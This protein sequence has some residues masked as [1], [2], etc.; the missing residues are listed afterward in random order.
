M[1]CFTIIYRNP[2]YEDIIPFL[3]DYFCFNVYSLT[4]VL[5][6][7][8]FTACDDKPQVN[9][10]LIEVFEVYIPKEER[11]VTRNPCE[12]FIEV[13]TGHDEKNRIMLDSPLWKTKNLHQ[14]KPLGLHCLLI[15][16][17]MHKALSENIIENK[18]IIDDLPSE[19]LILSP[20]KLSPID[21]PSK[22]F[23]RSSSKS[24]SA[25]LSSLTEAELAQNKNIRT[26]LEAEEEA[27]IERETSGRRG[28]VSVDKDNNKFSLEAINYMKGCLTSSL[29]YA[30][31]EFSTE[32]GFTYDALSDF[33]LYR[34]FFYIGKGID[35][36]MERLCYYY[37]TSLQSCYFI[38]EKVVLP[39]TPTYNQSRSLKEGSKIFNLH[40]IG[41]YELL[42]KRIKYVFN[43]FNLKI[44]SH[45]SRIRTLL[46]KW[47]ELG[48]TVSTICY[49]PLSE[50]SKLLDDKNT[51]FFKEI[52]V[53]STVRV[54]EKCRNNGFQDLARSHSFSALKFEST[55]NSEV[56]IELE[57]KMDYVCLGLV[58]SGITPKY[59]IL[60]T[61]DG[62]NNFCIRLCYFT[63][64]KFST[65]FCTVKRMGFP[66]DWNCYI[67]LRAPISQETKYDKLSNWY[68]NARLPV[69]IEETRRHVECT[70]SVPLKVHL[71]LQSKNEESIEMMKILKDYGQTLA[72]LGSSYQI[73][74]YKFFYNADV[75]IAMTRSLKE[76]KLCLHN[77]PPII[78]LNVN[79]ILN[80]SNCHLFLPQDTKMT[81]LEP[82]ILKAKQLF[83]SFK[84]AIK[85]YIIHSAS[86]FGL[87]TIMN[88]TNF[89][90][91]DKNYY[92]IYIPYLSLP[93]I[94]SSIF[95]NP[96]ISLDKPRASEKRKHDELTTKYFPKY[97]AYE[98]FTRDFVLTLVVV[99][100]NVSA[101]SFV[102]L[103]ILHISVS[104]Y[105]PNINYEKLFWGSIDT[106]TV[107]QGLINT[108]LNNSLI[109]FILYFSVVMV[110][111]SISAQ[112]DFITIRQYFPPFHNR[113]WFKYSFLTILIHLYIVNRIYNSDNSVQLNLFPL[114]SSR[115]ISFVLFYFTLDNSLSIFINK[116]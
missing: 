15:N 51:L 82:F 91:L 42:H 84:Q 30:L 37:G 6:M 8:R 58:A 47:S 94:A 85:F 98:N 43:G 66:V 114:F 45:D 19:G 54:D 107:S 88:S 64:A 50:N 26:D 3:S 35:T 25:I 95:F 67:N 73:S 80:T 7:D 21:K 39:D 89:P 68:K 40:V 70:D 34:S 63:P 31:E 57:N 65:V 81:I 111:H 23:L 103:Y 105:F 20:Y 24:S 38:S 29:T 71:Y 49:S 106:S 108:A 22:Q 4:H 92:L 18:K 99:T 97:S 83:I 79:E 56:Q 16:S 41:E 11:N 69:G 10:L 36:K 5:L 44:F 32:I 115:F 101:F 96:S 46:R 17:F 109:Y 1:Y 13:E 55:I 90:T 62:L 77:S 75:A 60:D 61:L 102:Y 86:L 104:P 110:F 48:Y 116:C 72:C 14:I 9:S 33:N 52:P 93:I 78:A 12:A 59:E 76:Y 53:K 28:R 100:I 74:S 87:V 2:S 27:S 112:K 113:T